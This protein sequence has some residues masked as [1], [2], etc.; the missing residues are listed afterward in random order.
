MLDEPSLGLAP[1]IV[2]QIFELLAELHREGTTILLIEQNAARTVDLVD[3]FY[4][5][6]A[7]GRV[8]FKGSRDDIADPDAFQAEYLGFKH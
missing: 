4:V 1:K 5:L 7:G 2:D 6:R 3:R 8:G